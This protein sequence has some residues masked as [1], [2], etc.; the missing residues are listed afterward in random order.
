MRNILFN[1]SGMSDLRRRG[2]SGLWSTLST[3]LHLLAYPSA[4][5]GAA[6]R[7]FI[8]WDSSMSGRCIATVFRRGEGCDWAGFVAFLRTGS[9]PGFVFILSSLQSNVMLHTSR[10]QA[11]L[12]FREAS[13]I[14]SRS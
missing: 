7:R 6:G 11:D 3:F 12:A 13:L 1:L 10:F 2:I 14:P 9:E 4:S 8:V 5:K